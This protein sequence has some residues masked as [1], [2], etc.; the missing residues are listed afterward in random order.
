[1]GRELT[2][3][4]PKI[5]EL[6]RDFFVPVAMDDWY[7]RRRKDQEGDFFRR[8][9]NQGPRKD[10]NGTRQGIYA[11]TADGRLLNYRNAQ[12]PAVMRR[13]LDDALTAWRDLPPAERTKGA[14]K[15]EALTALDNRFAPTLP[16]GAIIVNTYARILDRQEGFFCH[17][18]C[19]FP[20]GQRASHDHLWIRADEWQPL[21]PLDAKQGQEVS[22]PIKLRYRIARFSLVDNTRGEPPMWTPPEVRKENLKLI[23]EEVTASEV[24]LKLTGGYL[25]YTSANEKTAKRG[26]DAAIQGDIR[27]DLAKR[28][29]TKFSVVALG[30]HWGEGQYTGGARPGRTPLGVAFE[31]GDPNRP[32][33]RVAPQFMREGGNYWNAER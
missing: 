14:M 15:V 23:V 8:V 10:P 33:D 30:D 19:K 2:F 28:V 20:G 12:D 9:A 11:L 21:L 17:G 32:A 26:Y 29:L 25:L 13:F 18:T 3:A 4:N 27:Y 5:I 1:M 22:I 7:Q 24:R 6:V 16:P 31:L